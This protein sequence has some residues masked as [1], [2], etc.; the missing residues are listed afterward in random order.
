MIRPRLLEDVEVPRARTSSVISTALLRQFTSLIRR[1]LPFDSV[2]DFVGLDSATFWLW[3]KK[4][5]RYLEGDDGDDEDLAPYGL[6]VR[7][8]RKAF[9]EF[10]LQVIDQ[11][12]K[13]KPT[14]W[15]RD[16]A[17][18]ERRDRRNW[19]RLEI[20]GGSE[21]GINPDDRFL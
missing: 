10:K 9:A 18:L 7:G 12:M 20:A 3:M 17:I 11:L 2:C 13:E 16:I 14:T 6:F 4:G 1:G 21:D 8:V 19:S 5:D 15:M